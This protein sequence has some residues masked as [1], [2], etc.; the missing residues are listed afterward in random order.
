MI[1]RSASDLIGK[2]WMISNASKMAA[3]VDRLRF[4]FNSS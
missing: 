1:Y 2:L 3:K 4:L